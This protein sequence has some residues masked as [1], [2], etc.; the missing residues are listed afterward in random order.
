MVMRARAAGAVKLRGIA[1]A[2]A[3]R[4]LAVAPLGPVMSEPPGQ[5]VRPG[6]PGSRPALAALAV[7]R[8]VYI[9]PPAIGACE[10]A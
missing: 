1:A 6:A 8:D 2:A 9:L 10:G 3:A 7:D 4:W 5:L